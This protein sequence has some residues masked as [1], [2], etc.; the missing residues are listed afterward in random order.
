[1]RLQRRT[2]IHPAMILQLSDQGH[3]ILETFGNSGLLFQTIE[4]YWNG[5]LVNSYSEHKHN[6]RDRPHHN[7]S[8]PAAAHH[9]E[10]ERAFTSQ[11]KTLRST[12]HI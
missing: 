7:P 1:M 2:S 6:L 10:R 11:R 8:F 5:P 12:C 4:L 3:T 9:S